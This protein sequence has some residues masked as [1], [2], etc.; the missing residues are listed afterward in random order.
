MTVTTYVGVGRG[1]Y[2]FKTP[3]RS[4]LT[5][6]EIGNRSCSTE[7]GPEVED[8]GDAESSN[9]D[10]LIL[11]EILHIRYHDHSLSAWIEGQRLRKA[12]LATRTKLQSPS[13][14]VPLVEVNTRISGNTSP[15]RYL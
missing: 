9:E 3:V 13:V 11:G 1:T 8:A 15:K 4:R 12:H 14:D 6:T 2:E 5:V 7:S 10:A